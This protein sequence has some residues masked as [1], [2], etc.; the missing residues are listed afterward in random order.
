MELS[1]ISKFIETKSKL[2]IIRGTSGGWGDEKSLLHVCKVLAGVM[3]VLE[4]DNGDGFTTSI[5][6]EIV[7]MVV[8]HVNVINV[9]ELYT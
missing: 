7:M 5:Y 1:R 4:I 2:E 3:K 8:Q 6:L 9:T